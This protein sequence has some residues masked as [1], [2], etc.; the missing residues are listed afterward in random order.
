[1]IIWWEH[2]QQCENMKTIWTDYLVIAGLGLEALA[3][4]ATVYLTTSIKTL[5]QTANVLEANPAARSASTNYYLQFIEFGVLAGFMITYY[6]FI[7][8]KAMTDKNWDFF[9]T[10]FVIIFFILCLFDFINDGSALLG[11]LVHG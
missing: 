9:V 1:M 6:I 3:R 8:R 11:V 7:R 4:G 5:V 10:A 2:L